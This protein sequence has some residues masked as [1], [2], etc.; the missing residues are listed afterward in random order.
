MTTKIVWSCPEC[1]SFSVNR[2]ACYNVNNGEYSMFDSASC[3][4]CSYESDYGFVKTVVPLDFDTD[5]DQLP[6][7]PP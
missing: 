1:G 6:T 7:K 2:D 3:G 5:T 4:D